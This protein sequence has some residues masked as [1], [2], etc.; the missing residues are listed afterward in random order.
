[1]FDHGGRD[2]GTSD[3]VFSQF[4]SHNEPFDSCI[5]QIHYSS[6]FISGVGFDIDKVLF[7]LFA[8]GSIISVV[9][10][11]IHFFEAELFI[12]IFIGDDADDDVVV[13]YGNDSDVEEVFAFAGQ[14]LTVED[15]VGW[16]V[17]FDDFVVLDL[18]FGVVFAGLVYLYVKLFA[19]LL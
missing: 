2:V 18:E 8:D 15:L 17:F 12:F 16:A 13:F 6:D 7:V 4:S 19:E 14:R 10:H 3:G 1:M 11:A 9:A 5:S